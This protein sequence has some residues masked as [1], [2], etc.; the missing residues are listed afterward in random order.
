MPLDR[1]KKFQKYHLSQALRFSIVKTNVATTLATLEIYLVE[2][3]YGVH[4]P[5]AQTM[6]LLAHPQCIHGNRQ[7]DRTVK[8]R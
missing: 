7:H 1:E 8:V 6:P 3:R 5:K 2:T 4:A